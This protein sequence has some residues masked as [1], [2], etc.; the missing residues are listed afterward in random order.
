LHVNWV[1]ATFLFHRKNRRVAGF[2]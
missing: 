1:L 2:L